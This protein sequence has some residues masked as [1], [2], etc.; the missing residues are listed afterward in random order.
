MPVKNC[1]ERRKG[2]EIGK[3]KVAERASK[4]CNRSE[5]GSV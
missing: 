3:H 4:G 5:K 1:V 2:G